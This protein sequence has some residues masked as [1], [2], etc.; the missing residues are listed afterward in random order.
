MERRPLRSRRTVYAE[1]HEGTQA[2][3]P[4]GRERAR[5]PDRDAPGN[6]Q[7]C[8]PADRAL[9]AR[10]GVRTH[11]RAV[12]IEPSELSHA[13]ASWLRS[14]FPHLPPSLEIPKVR[15]R[16]GER[17]PLFVRGAKDWE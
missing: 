1:G 13:P 10:Y 8:R 5:S 16:L 3:L 4:D 12:S 14:G 7:R 2:S 17:E 6:N 9:V 11:V 15:E